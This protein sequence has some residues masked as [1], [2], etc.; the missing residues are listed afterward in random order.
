MPTNVYDWLTQTTA[1]DVMVREVATVWP[2]HTLA[3]V[4]AVLLREQIS[5][6]PVVSPE[7]VCVGVF[8]LV[9]VLRAEEQIVDERWRLAHSSYFT[10]ELAWPA[11]VYADKLAEFQDK[12]S[13][14]AERPVKEFMTKNLVSLV[15]EARLQ[16]VV[17]KMVD[18]H[19]HRVLI[20]D[21]RGRL[22]GIITT[23]DLLAALRQFATLSS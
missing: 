14:A 22:E 20:V 9:D 23:M 19:V 15:P 18:A 1:S 13:P 12:M 7:G 6:V 17:E 2:T 21:A 16:R 8:S 5:G 11:S 4:A 10:S 3:Q